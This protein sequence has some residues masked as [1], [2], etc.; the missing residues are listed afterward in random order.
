MNSKSILRKLQIYM[1]GFGIAMG[2]VFPIYANFFVEFKDGMLVF[3]VAGCL[4]AGV[5]VGLVSFLFVKL[6]LLKK[7]KEVSSVAHN[8]ENKNISDTINIES[9]DDVGTIVNGINK[10]IYNIRS[11]FIEMN[12]VFEL[13]EQALKSVNKNESTHSKSALEQIDD[14]IIEVTDYTK[15]I[16]HYSNQI[17]ESVQKGANISECTREKQL[18]TI[19]KVD[20]FSKIMDSLVQHSKKIEGI[21]KIIEE[22][23]GQTNILSL[24]ASVEAARAGEA[25]KGFAVVAQEIRKL[26]SNTSESSQTIAST[27]LAIQNDV[28]TANKQVEDINAW[29]RNNNDDITSINKQFKNINSS[30]NSNI[31]HNQMLVSSV[32]ELSSLFN[33]VGN[34]FNELSQNLVQIQAVVGSYK[35]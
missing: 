33:N 7:L 10:A 4:M 27:I 23:A 3:F 17:I 22:I 8:I 1:L 11:L 25:G 20:E 6:I 19:N 32:N 21:L 31:E 9:N 28:K 30:L 35:Y 16:E 5:T 15:K 14:A 18:G 2:I 26:A 24:N 13:S 29:V 12:K 34:V